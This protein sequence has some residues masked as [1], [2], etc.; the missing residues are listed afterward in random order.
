MP[1]A[2]ALTPID[3]RSASILQA[4]LAGQTGA[5]IANTLGVTP[6]AV[7]M[8]LLRHAADEWRDHQAA[9]A[10][11]RL[12]RAEE[13]IGEAADGLALGRA[14]EELRSA[15]WSLERLARRIYG[16]QVAL[17]GADQGPLQVQIVRFGATIEGQATDLGVDSGVTQGALADKSK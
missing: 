17:T 13:K 7:Y 10:L 11:W 4:Y 12:E 3:Q 16:Q 9:R 1:A 2:G 5:Q 14:R 15:Q 8:H 6:E